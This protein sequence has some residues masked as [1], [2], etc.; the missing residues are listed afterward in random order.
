MKKLRYY[1]DVNREHHLKKINFEN[2]VRKM[3]T[4]VTTSII[5]VA[6]VA[7][8]AIICRTF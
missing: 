8:V 1:T 2:E 6:V 7:A 5:C 3:V 4:V